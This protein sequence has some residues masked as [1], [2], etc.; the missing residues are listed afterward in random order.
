MQRRVIFNRWFG[1]T[2][3]VLAWLGLCLAIVHPPHGTGV[4]VCLFSSSVGMPCPGCGMTRSLSCAARGLFEESWSYHP[5]GLLLLMLFT[6]TAGLS[7][8]PGATRRR[9][10]AS[11]MRHHRAVTFVYIAFIVS[12]A[13]FG[14][15]RSIAHLIG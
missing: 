15:V 2:S 5:F 14:A 6:C 8:L 3:V 9:F 7:L 11:V 10:A 12:F 4:S 1:K 13:T